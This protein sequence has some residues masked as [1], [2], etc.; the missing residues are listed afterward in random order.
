MD[1][2]PGMLAVARAAAPDELPIDWYETSAEAMPLQDASFDVILCQMGLQFMS[3]K[4]GALAEMHRVLAPGGRVVITLP[5]P[6][7]P[8]FT[9]LADALTKNI[10]PDAGKFAHAVFSLHDAGQIRALLTDAGFDKVEVEAKDKDLQLPPPADF[11]WQYVYSTP[12]GGVVAKA[13]EQQKV[14][15]ERDVCERWRQFAS[16]GGMK[17]E[18]TMN[19]VTAAK[20][21][22]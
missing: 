8:M 10:R 2:N 9:A 16:G 7:P 18:L 6:T 12:L 1:I 15:L 20:R 14:A 11:L 21:A 22:A 4:A 3:N 13:S 19:T 5:G 17:L